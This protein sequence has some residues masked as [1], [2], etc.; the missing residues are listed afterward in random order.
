ME[1]CVTVGGGDMGLS[2]EL[3]IVTLK[4][5]GSNADSCVNVGLKISGGGLVVRVGGSGDNMGRVGVFRL[6]DGRLTLFIS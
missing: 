2:V 6:D 3:A 5:R 1:V 4:S